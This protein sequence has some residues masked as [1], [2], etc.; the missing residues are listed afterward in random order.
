MDINEADE[1]K[2]LNS[3][4][5]TLKT[6]MTQIYTRLA[7]VDK[8]KP[9]NYVNQREKLFCIYTKCPV[10]Y[11]QLARSGYFHC[12]HGICVNCYTKLNKACCP[13]CRST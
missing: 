2:S 5:E 4:L 7:I 9:A 10:C 8:A 3:E 12:K 11:D 1:I 13:L 6:R